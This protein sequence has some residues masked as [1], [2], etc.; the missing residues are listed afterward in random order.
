MDKT[1][2]NIGGYPVVTERHGE[3]DYSICFPVQDYSVRGTMLDNVKAFAEW[4]W[5]NLTDPLISFEHGDQRISNPWIDHSARF[6][7]DNEKA[8]ME[9]GEDNILQFIIDACIILRSDT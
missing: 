4:Q 5:S 8:C 7:L 2:M 3:N 1:T 9:Y 6:Q